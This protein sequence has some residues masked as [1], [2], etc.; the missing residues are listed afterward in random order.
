MGR[1]NVG[2]STLLN[3][4]LGLKLSITSRKPQTTRHRLRGVLT[5]GRDQL[6]FVD[7]PGMHRPRRLRALNRQLNE[8]AQRALNDVDAVVLVVDRDHWT[9]TDQWV[10]EQVF[11]RP[12]PVVIAV[13]KVDLVRP[14]ERLLPH[15]QWLA[16]RF[17]QAELVPVAALKGFNLDRLVDILAGWL[18]QGPFLFPPDQLTDR[19]LR[20]L[21]AERVREKLVRQLGD[22]LPYATAVEIEQWRERGGV[23]HIHALIAVERPSQKAI[24][25]GEGGERL[26]KIGQQARLDLERLLGARV[27]LHLWVKVR[28]DWADDERAL[29]ALGY[30]ERD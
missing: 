17:P 21:A 25:I 6:V 10:A 11:A 15:F 26:K 22:E 8:T 14:R 20:F 1:P 7:T 5:R 3:H 13:N 28:E 27:M 24:V 16:E 12:R 18:P 4:L 23:V 30:D 2:K 19:S 29:R 9:D